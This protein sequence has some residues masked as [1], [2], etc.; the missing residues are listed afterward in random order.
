MA[1]GRISG[2]TSNE[3]VITWIDWSSS[4]NGS[5][6]NSSN[7]T[8]VLYAQRTNTGYQTYGNGTGTININGQDH[9]FSF[10]SNVRIT[11][12][13]TELAR[14]STTVG[15]EDN[16]TK[17]CYIAATWA[18]ATVVSAPPF[19]AFV[20]LDTIPR[21]PEVTIS[22]GNTSLTTA[23]VHVST[24]DPI[25]GLWYQVNGGPN[26]GIPHTL[27]TFNVPDLSPGTSY[28]INC[29]STRSDS[30]LSK[31]SN[32][33]TVT[34]KAVASITSSIN[35][36]I[37][38]DL[39]L[40]FS[41][42]GSGALYLRV[43]INNTLI[44]SRNNATSGTSYTISFSDSEVLA[45][46]EAAD[47]S[48]P[49]PVRVECDT[50][51]GGAKVGSTT[52]KTGSASARLIFINNPMDFT[53]GEPLSIEFSNPDKL[54]AQFSL[55]V[56]GV[57][58]LVQS[59]GVTTSPFLW[60]FTEEDVAAIYAA[61][62]DQKA[63][64]VVVTCTTLYAGEAIGTST[65]AGT[66]S[67]VNSEPLFTGYT[68]TD[69]N[70]DTTALTG[71]SSIFVKGY[72]TAHFVISPATAQNSASIV[73]YTLLAGSKPLTTDANTLQ[74]DIE[75]IDGPATKV[76]AIDSREFSTSIEQE[77]TFKDYFQPAISQLSLTRANHVDME[78]TLA[79][80]GTFWNN[81]FGAVQ[82][83]PVL[84]YRFK[85]TGTGFSDWIAVTVSVSGS[86]VSALASLRGD[87]GTGGADGFN[88]EN[89]Y[90]LEFRLR[91][92][93]S[94]AVSSVVLDRGIPAMLLKK[95]SL[96]VNG[97]LTAQTVAD[98]SGNSL[99][100][101]NT[102][103]LSTG[104]LLKWDGEKVV[105]TEMWPVGSVYISVSNVNPSTLFGG[106]WVSFASGRTL[107]GVDTAQT[108]FNAVQKTGGNKTVTLTKDQL[109]SLSPRIQ[110][111]GSAKGDSDGF[112]W[113]DY[114]PNSPEKT[115]T[116]V[117]FPKND[118]VGGDDG[119]LHRI[120][121]SE[122]IRRSSPVRTETFGNNEA[123]N[124]LQPY[125]TV[126]FWQRTA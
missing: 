44:A 94:A 64:G 123:H 105:S 74:A 103:A 24:N 33:V 100:A 41:N 32:T 63:P 10:D 93:L 76:T 111:G 61:S 51:S 102:A 6:A 71:D 26:I 80:S 27:R 16:G 89:S 120:W 109:P 46:Y 4:S 116:N 101:L 39:S 8:A 53:V 28:S 115:P 57:S 48:S 38:S 58:D 40:S 18:I 84:E 126:Y 85:S 121:N 52:S 90:D 59:G 73:K 15:H 96:E 22:S 83:Q 112:I 106:T 30:G 21:Y 99:A 66:A 1:N 50:Y 98:K 23:T 107:V 68:V 108:E 104:N 119:A 69:A 3:R 17:S 72:S 110:L 62:P 81:S 43:Y 88:I 70:P 78:T 113:G 82:N 7:V 19:H 35:W 42:P 124:N 14:F 65:K 20:S 49:S 79:F 34:T 118:N 36:Q 11:S 29:V 37:G 13:P 87:M 25:T 47:G 122:G 77:V 5:S 86:K 114:L 95:D 92:K 91:D 31:A 12:N 55:S 2:S 60:E 56:N 54:V 97:S 117:W 67:I 125:I 9:H 75:Q 45:A